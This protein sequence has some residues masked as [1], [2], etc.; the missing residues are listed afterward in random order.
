MSIQAKYKSVLALGQELG[1]VDGTVTEADGVLTVTGTVE[2]EYDKN[3]LWDKIKSVGGATPS[4]IIADIR[5]ATTDYYA[6]YT[7]ASGDT[8]GKIAKKFYN[9]P[10][11]YTA[12][13]SANTDILEH[14]DKIEIGQILT[15]PFKPE[16]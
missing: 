14:P 3:L 11:L 5:V 13:F 7:V 8:L 15:I 2:T 4:D 1:A 10:K 9:A 16:A 12:I 6:K